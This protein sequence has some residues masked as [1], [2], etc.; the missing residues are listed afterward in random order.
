MQHI[1]LEHEK[2][3]TKRKDKNGGKKSQKQMA[4]YKFPSPV[5]LHV[6]YYTVTDPETIN[7][8]HKQ[9]TL[10]HSWQNKAKE[11]FF[12]FILFCLS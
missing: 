10:R 12:W 9:T 6:H 5:L 1:K 8:T 2:R 3:D 7:L 4:I 11:V